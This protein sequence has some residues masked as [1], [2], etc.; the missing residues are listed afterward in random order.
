M[1]AGADTARK[2]R[3]LVAVAL[4]GGCLRGGFVQVSRQWQTRTPFL[5]A[6]VPARRQILGA[7]QLL[8]ECYLGLPLH[9]SAV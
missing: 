9:S 5:T 6:R 3:M 7:L 2:S 1:V 4:L 8:L